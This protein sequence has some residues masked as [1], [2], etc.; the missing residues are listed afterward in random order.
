MITPDEHVSPPSPI[1]KQVKFFTYLPYLYGCSF[2]L[3]LHYLRNSVI[4]KLQLHNFKKRFGGESCLYDVNMHKGYYI[5]C[6]LNCEKRY[7]TLN[8]TSRSSVLGSCS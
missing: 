3:L 8:A 2:Q 4:Q 1:C 7:T 5:N 6:T